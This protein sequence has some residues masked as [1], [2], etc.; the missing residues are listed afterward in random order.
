KY[1]EYAYGNYKDYSS[2]QIGFIH[3]DQLDW[4]KDDLEKTDKPTMIF[5]HEPTFG[6][7]GNR[8]AFR[9]VVYEE[10]E[11]AKNVIAVFSGHYHD[12]WAIKRDNI[13]YIQI[14]S[15]SYKYVGKNKP[16]V[17]NREGYGPDVIKD[18]PLVP[19]LA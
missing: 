5:F 8:D 12:N 4:L 19:Y 15:A 3:P 10:T 17:T 1:M 6:S 16:P 18:F 2:S 9:M 13:H 11:K 14:N 7:L